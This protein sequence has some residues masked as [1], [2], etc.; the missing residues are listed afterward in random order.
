MIVTHFKIEILLYLDYNHIEY[1]MKGD[2]K[3]PEN[4][5]LFKNVT[6]ATEPPPDYYS[7]LAV[8]FAMAGFMLR[9][10]WGA[11][12][13]LLTFFGGYTNSRSSS[14]DYSQMFTTFS[15][16]LIS[17]TMNYAWIFRF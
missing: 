16:I 11:W 2:P 5:I 17:L 6:R 13:G 9:A 14:V 4:I 1:N 10:K 12:L 8:M 3:R 7:F 15:M